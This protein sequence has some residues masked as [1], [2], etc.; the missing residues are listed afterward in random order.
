MFPSSNLY[1]LKD[2]QSRSISCQNPTGAKG[3]ALKEWNHSVEK[4]PVGE[5]LCI[6]DI[7]G[8]G[9]VRNIWLT[10]R[11]R[12]PESLRNFIIRVYYDHND[13]P[14]VE[15]PIGDFFGLSHGR[16]AHFNTPVVGVSEGK[17]F[18][19]YF[20]MPFA[21]HCRITFEN[22][23]PEVERP[24]NRTN[25]HVNL[26]Y[27]IMYTLGDQV[28]DD[29][30]YFHAQFRRDMP[31]IGSDY[32]LMQTEG[33]PGV[34]IGSVL[35]ALP[36][37]AGTWREGDFRFYI[38]GDE[39]MPSIIGTGWSDWFLSAWGL[40]E[41]QSP[42]AGSNYQVIHPEMN[43][44]YFCNSYRF[45]LLDPIY[46]SNDL[47]VDHTQVGATGKD[48]AWL[49]TTESNRSEDWSSTAYWYQ[50]L[51]GKGFDSFPD[52]DVR[53]RGIAITEWE[54]E[55]REKQLADSAD[56]NRRQMYNLDFGG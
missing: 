12:D 29:T 52:R 49:N 14:S 17:G 41:H 40:G 51:T 28:D 13:Y 7:E 22:D 48:H 23:R 38:D 43:N 15:A 21:K 30:G 37:Q 36:Q 46:F 45:H 4:L 24:D 26:Y 18:W 9:M 8:P 27:Q 35:S 50:R 55:A 5:T 31:P 54:A 47:R 11:D 33:T 19:C 32:T 6:A 25:D 53:T 34:Y 2:L 56:R 39:P 1:Q 16:T 44:K 10:V 20:Q 3:G 42:Y